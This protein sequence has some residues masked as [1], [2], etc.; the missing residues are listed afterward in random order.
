MSGLPLTSVLLE[1]PNIVD[2]SANKSGAIT[3]ATTELTHQVYMDVSAATLNEYFRWERLNGTTGT[4]SA[5]ITD[6]S[7]L[8]TALTAPALVET[9]T[10]ADPTNLPADTKLDFTVANLDAGFRPV[11]TMNTLVMPY[12]LFKLFGRSDISAAVLANTTP[13]TS[14]NPL[15]DNTSWANAYVTELTDNSGNIQL[16]FEQLMQDIGR[17]DDNKAIQAAIYNVNYD[18]PDISGNWN[19]QSGDIIQ[20]TTRFTFANKIQFS[21]TNNLVPNPTS[22][23]IISPGDQFVINFQ[24]R[25]I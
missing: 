17:F 24:L 15:L 2:I 9:L 13:L 19:F 5:S 4:P 1:Y 25:S 6:A 14:G 20:F 10:D 3:L 7:G 12:V 8:F 23:P 22:L 18:G 16:M 11:Y 21:N